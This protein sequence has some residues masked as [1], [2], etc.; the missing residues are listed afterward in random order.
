MSGKHKPNT[1]GLVKG[2]DYANV[3]SGSQAEALLLADGWKPDGSDDDIAE[4]AK[5][6]RGGK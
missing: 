3:D 6:K 2:D 5:K 1:I 4:P